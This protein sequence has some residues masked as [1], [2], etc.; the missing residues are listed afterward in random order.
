[1]P[2]V[3]EFASVQQKMMVEE[4]FMH[5][6]KGK[7]PILKTRTKEVS[8]TVPTWDKPAVDPNTGRTNPSHDSSMTDAEVLR[9]V[10]DGISL[11]TRQTLSAVQKT[12]DKDLVDLYKLLTGE[13][14]QIVTIKKGI[15]Q[16]AT[17][18]H[19]TARVI[20]VETIHIWLS[21]DGGARFAWKAIGVSASA[22]GALIPPCVIQGVS[23]R[24]SV[25][26]DVLTAERLQAALLPVEQPV[27]LPV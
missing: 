3:Y 8:V 14:T 4:E 21:T 7:S 10:K 27:E 11:L 9:L 16:R 25:S 17:K 26:Y 1:M 20:G 23:R 18:P 13:R 24:G 6:R 22:G 2:I 15:H 5:K 12:N 19:I